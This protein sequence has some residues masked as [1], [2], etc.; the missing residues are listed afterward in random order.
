[1]KCLFSL[2]LLCLL[3]LPV[4]ASGGTSPETLARYGL[5]S[6]P[7]EADDALLL[8]RISSLGW[9]KGAVSLSLEVSCSGNVWKNKE[10]EDGFEDIVIDTQHGKIEIESMC[11][12]MADSQTIV[13]LENG[14]LFDASDKD[15]DLFE[16]LV[17]KNVTARNR[18]TGRRMNRLNRISLF[19]HDFPI[20]KRK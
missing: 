3:L 19:E 11:T 17:I 4:C 2:M 10:T 1:M 8:L 15:M 14:P 7:R 9:V 18:K 12:C 13:R 16:S 20:V 6:L 5:Q